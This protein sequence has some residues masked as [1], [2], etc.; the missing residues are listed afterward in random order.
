[1]VI[2]I[3]VCLLIGLSVMICLSYRST[4]KVYN[5]FL[6]GQE[7]IR[8]LKASLSKLERFKN[9]NW[10]RMKDLERKYDRLRLSMR[11]LAGFKTPYTEEDSEQIKII[12]DLTLEDIGDN[13]NLKPETE[14]GEE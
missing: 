13:V 7:E 8:I 5:D 6:E 9:P 12:I 4:K 14:G 3:N 10:V 1:M 2:V 11:W